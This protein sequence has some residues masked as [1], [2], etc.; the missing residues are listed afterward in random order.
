[1][2]FKIDENLPGDLLVDL[3][4]AGHDADSVVD[5]NLGGAPDPD[6]LEAATA[7][8][9]VLLTL[10]KGIANL[11]QHP[12]EKHAGVVLF[13]PGMSGRRVVLQFIRARLPDLFARDLE[14]A[15]TIV[16]ETRIRVR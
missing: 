6:V 15:V 5:E 4:V 8:H 7:E 14:H 10:D 13:R 1:V 12:R 3:R 2:R 11:L 9:R 16:S